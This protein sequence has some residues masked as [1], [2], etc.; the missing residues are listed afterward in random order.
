MNRGFTVS[1]WGVRGVR[2]CFWFLTT[3]QPSPGAPAAASS[4]RLHAEASLR[5]LAQKLGL[6]RWQRAQFDPRNWRSIENVPA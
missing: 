4:C 1:N 3:P 2:V 5:D 6:S